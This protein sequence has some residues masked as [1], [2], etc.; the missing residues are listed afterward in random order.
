MNA[1]KSDVAIGPKGGTSRQPLKDKL[2]GDMNGGI[3]VIEKNMIRVLAGLMIIVIVYGAYS[4]IL[5][6]NIN[7][8]IEKTNKIIEDTDSKITKIKAYDKQ[9]NDRTNQYETVI[10]KIDANEQ[11]NNDLINSKNAIPNLLHEIMFA[12]PKEVQ[13]LSIKNPSGKRVTIEAQSEDYSQLGYF[14]AKLTQEMALTNVTVS[15]GEKSEGFI[16]VTIQGDLPC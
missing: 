2:K 14:K 4:K 7:T 15:A 8:D 16:K 11:K 5:E 9:V 3:D 13:V 1:L 12:I 10:A 6:K